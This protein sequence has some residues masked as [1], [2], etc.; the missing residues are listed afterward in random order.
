[1]DAFE[2]DFDARVTR[3]RNAIVKEIEAGRFEKSD[4][5]L[6]REISIF[7]SQNCFIAENLF[8]N[9]E[10]HFSAENDG[11]D[12]PHLKRM[13]SIVDP[14]SRRSIEK[15]GICSQ[16]NEM[17][18]SRSKKV[19]HGIKFTNCVPDNRDAENFIRKRYVPKGAC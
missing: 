13:G 17:M 10:D 1:M 16:K 8:G 12:E 18:S 4:E 3:I 7:T 9:M 5:L 2:S 19:Y 15:T 14:S 6:M 11:K